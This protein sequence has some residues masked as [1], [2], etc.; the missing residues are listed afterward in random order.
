[1]DRLDYIYCLFCSTRHEN[2]VSKV[3]RNKGYTVIP[4][5]A[6][7]D[8]VQ[9]GNN[10][11]MIRHLLPGYV[12]FG[13]GEKITITDERKI[14]S[15]EYMIRLLNYSDGTKELR[16]RDLEFVKLFIN[17]NG[18]IGLLEAIEVGS[19]VTITEG[20]LKDFNG[21]VV[22]VNRKRKCALVEFELFENNNRVWLSYKVMENS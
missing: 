3:L 18:I 11:Q 9:G 2:T 15:N 17:N 12:F 10:K 21:E 7:R 16:G 20:S 1:M 14:L 22:K 13:V 19:W 6:K 4:I 8:T 5:M